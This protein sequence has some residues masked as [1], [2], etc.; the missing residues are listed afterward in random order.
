MTNTENLLPSMPPMPSTLPFIP[1]LHPQSQ[2]QPHP[3][4]LKLFASLDIE[5]DGNNPSQHSMLSLGISFM[6]TEGVIVSEQEYHFPP[7]R[8]RTYDPKC[9]SEF[10]MKPEQQ[11]AWQVLQTNLITPQKG[12][13]QLATC[14][15]HF[16]Q[17]GFQIMW[18]AWPSAFDWS[19]LKSYYEEY[20]PLNKP[21]IGYRCLDI[22]SVMTSMAEIM[23]IKPKQFIQQFRPINPTPHV[24]VADARVQGLTFVN[25]NRWKHSLYSFVKDACIPTMF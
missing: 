16:E 10:W 11:Q 22:G 20:G 24:A 2:S 3:Q 5:A 25:F 17:Q 8:D 7:R 19:F 14:L 4:P 9:F 21:D 1:V 23:R 6:T 18:L 13:L 15:Q 12:M